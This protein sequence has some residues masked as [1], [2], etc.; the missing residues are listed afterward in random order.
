M[1][2]HSGTRV[3]KVMERLVNSYIGNSK[4]T[5]GEIQNDYSEYTPQQFA[6]LSLYANNLI[7]ELKSLNTKINKEEKLQENCK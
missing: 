1:R 7:K 4:E 6:K 2:E 5:I 3:H